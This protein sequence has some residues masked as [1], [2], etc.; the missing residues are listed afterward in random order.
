MQKYFVEARQLLA[1][2]IPVILAQIAQTAMGFVDTVMAG[3]YSATDMAAVAIGTSIWLPAILFGHGLLLALTPIIAQLNGSGRRDRVA[4]QV[5]QG[6]WLAGIVSILIMV[7]LWNAG[8]I[9]H[10]MKN[11]DPQLA[12]KAVGYLRALLWGAPGYLF[13][14]VARNQCEGLAKTKPGMVIGFFGLLVNIPVNY[15]FIYGHAGMPE[16][17]GVGCG[18]ATATVYWVMLACMLSYT[19]RARSMRDIQGP[20]GFTR[21]NYALLKRLVQLGLPIALALFFEVTLFAVVALLVSPLGIVDVAGHQIALNFSSLMFVLPMSLAAAVT[22]RVG[23]RLGEGSTANAQTAARTGLGVGVTMAMITAIFTIT[24]REHIALLYNDNPEVVTLAAH[25]ML[26]AAIYQISDSIQVVGSGILR[27]YK[28]T[29]SIFFITF[30]AYWVLGLPCGYTLALTD[31][32][33]PRM[34]P[35][36]FWIGFIIGL[37]SAAIMMMTRMGWLQR[38]PSN[39]ILKRAAR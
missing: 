20:K 9:I 32:V 38:Q 6:F 10:T 13:F 3:G 18:V 24:M 8:Y 12:D 23:F 25:L 29:R 16:L 7:V 26:L 17:G 15:I 37:T 4:V 1:L 35:A 28:D 11:I 34:G 36:G 30:I 22:I 5:R 33:V 19:K 39:L 14:Q 31:I 21:P 2:A 27:G